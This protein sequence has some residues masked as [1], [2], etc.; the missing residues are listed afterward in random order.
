[1]VRNKRDREQPK[2]KVY[3]KKSL[4]GKERQDREGTGRTCECWEEKKMLQNA[5]R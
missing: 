3:G 5:A 2:S 1:M 4:G